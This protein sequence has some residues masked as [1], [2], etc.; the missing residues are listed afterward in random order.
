MH[1]Q[2]GLLQNILTTVFLAG[3][4]LTGLAAMI[5][6]TTEGLSGTAVLLHAPAAYVTVHIN[7][8]HYTPVGIVII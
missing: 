4:G 3:L 2:L 5:N 1:R 8:T 7:S 6:V